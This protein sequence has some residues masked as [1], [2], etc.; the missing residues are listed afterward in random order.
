MSVL[1]ML[2]GSHRWESV[3]SLLAHL[4]QYLFMLEEMGR[5]GTGGFQG[6]IFVLLLLTLPQM[7]NRYCYFKMGPYLN[8]LL[9]FSPPL[10]CCSVAKGFSLMTLLGC[11]SELRHISPFQFHLFSPYIS[12][13]LYLSPS[14]ISLLSFYNTATLVVKLKCLLM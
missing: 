10:I 7:R 2:N 4:L 6:R 5:R 12:F 3:P 9:P 11:R 13:S 8:L 14:L 1:M